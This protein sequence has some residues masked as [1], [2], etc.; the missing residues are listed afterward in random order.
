[1]DEILNLKE[2]IKGYKITDNVQELPTEKSE[3]LILLRERELNTLNQRISFSRMTSLI[4]K[5]VLMNYWI[6][7]I[8]RSTGLYFLSLEVDLPMTG[9]T[10]R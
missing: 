3:L 7:I 10:S 1:M 2:Q 5:N 4:S 6:T 8:H 9:N